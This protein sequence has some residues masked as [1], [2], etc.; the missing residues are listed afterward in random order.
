GES[1]TML[2][3]RE[4]QQEKGASKATLDVA[5]PSVFRFLRTSVFVQFVLLLATTLIVSTV[6]LPAL[7][8]FIQPEAL[9]TDELMCKIPDFVASKQKYDVVFMGSSLVLAP[10][11]Y[12]DS[13]LLGKNVN[14]K[15]EKKKNSH[16]YNKALYFEKLLGEAFHRNVSVYNLGLPGCMVADDCIL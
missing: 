7:L 1:K 12:C 10:A 13:E 14:S 2:G 15:D 3:T 5:R 9:D 16:Y 11:V 6:A 8:K 4:R